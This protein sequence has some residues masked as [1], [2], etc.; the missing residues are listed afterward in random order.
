M[1]LAEA[2]ERYLISWQQKIQG[3]ITVR[4]VRNA[5]PESN[6]LAEFV[7]D[8]QK[9]VPAVAVQTEKI[10]DTE[11]PGLVLGDRW[12]FHAVPSGHK[13]ELFGEILLALHG[14]APSLEAKLRERWQK[15][16]LAP[17]LT[18]FVAPQCPF[19]PQVVRQIIPLS[20]ATPAATITLIDA[21]L[22]QELAREQEIK[23]V[24]TII[25]NGVYRLT[26][27]VQLSEL[28]ELAE[29]T[30]PAL[31][32]SSVWERMMQD[33]QAGL[34][35]ELMLAQGRIFPQFLPLLWHPEINIRLGAMVALET[36][37]E[38]RPDL[39]A[40]ILPTVWQELNQSDT[41]VQGDIVY[42]I[43]EWGGGDWLQPLVNAWQEVSHPDVAEAIE[44]AL[45]KIKERH[46]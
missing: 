18:I 41:A 28:V 24:P 29:K 1:V 2:D 35:G 30:D 32:P 33:G 4:F 36:V 26:G 46:P 38:A 23:A 17:A 21:T 22:F 42:L 40:A 7:K 15:L 20:V 3:P 13:L 11:L 39:I 19:C 6:P 8:W 12:H 10:P 16:P 43:G 5:R 44:E 45:E 34:A 37:G 31:L 27:A 9:L 14:P 25:C